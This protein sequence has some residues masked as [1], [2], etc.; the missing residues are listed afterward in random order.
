[1][2]RFAHVSI[3]IAAAL[4][5]SVPF[6][7]YAFP[8]GGSIG[9]IKPC[10]NDAI[11][12]SLGPPTPGPYIWTPATKT[13]QFGPPTHAGQWL[14]GLT[15]APYFCLVSIEPVIVWPGINI[16]MMGSSQ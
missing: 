8:F 13:Y 5:M 14:L 15:G 11:Y 1:M 16:T 7:S 6:V 2:N 9:L 3:G 12:A 10:Y 4:S